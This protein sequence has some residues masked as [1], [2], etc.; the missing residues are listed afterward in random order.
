MVFLALS[1]DY[2][3]NEY[4]SCCIHLSQI[5]LALE[6]RTLRTLYHNF[7]ENIGWTH[8]F[9]CARACGGARGIAGKRGNLFSSRFHCFKQQGMGADIDVLVY[10][11][12]LGC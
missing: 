2:E 4:C 9:T 1:S 10:H 8:T 12:D 7:R 11:I 5:L 3:A 6:I